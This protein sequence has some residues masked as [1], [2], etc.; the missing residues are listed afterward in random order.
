MS[1]VFGIYSGD[2]ICGT[3][4]LFCRFPNCLFGTAQKRE[5]FCAQCTRVSCMPMCCVSERENAKTCCILD[6]HTFL[7]YNKFIAGIK[8][9]C[10]QGC[11]SSRC[12]W[13]CDDEVPCVCF[14]CPCCL[15]CLDWQ[16]VGCVCCKTYR[17]IYALRDANRG[18]PPQQ[19]FQQEPEYPP[20]GVITVTAQPVT[21]PVQVVYQ[22]IE[23]T[24]KKA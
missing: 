3:S 12:A 14:P 23:M 7:F 2:S 11:F 13:P 24:D 6:R 20:Q 18:T 22:Q 5:C 8:C 21:A 19:K 15:F 17:E 9:M 16:I 10:Q 4:E 1:V